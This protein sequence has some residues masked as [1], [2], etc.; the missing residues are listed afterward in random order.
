MCVCVFSVEYSDIID[1]HI[2][3]CEDD[4]A[5]NEVSSIRRIAPTML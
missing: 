2:T 1:Y 4:N 3:L 5:L